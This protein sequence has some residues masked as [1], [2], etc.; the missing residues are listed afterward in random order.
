M[1]HLSVNFMKKF[2]GNIFEDNLWPT[3]YTYTP[4]RHATY[5]QNMYTHPKVKEYLEQH[6]TNLWFRSNFGGP[7]GPSGEIQAL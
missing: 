5:M 6:H 4:S 2:K 7:H 1:K 3:S